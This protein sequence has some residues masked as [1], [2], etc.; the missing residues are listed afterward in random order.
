MNIYDYIVVCFVA[1]CGLIMG[2]MF[3][4]PHLTDSR[5][6][7]ISDRVL[8]RLI[9]LFSLMSFVTAAYSF[10]KREW[11]TGGIFAF[12]VIIGLIVVLMVDTSEEL[13]KKNDPCPMT[14]SQWFLLH[15]GFCINRDGIWWNAKSGT[16]RLWPWPWKCERCHWHMGREWYVYDHAGHRVWLC[17][18]C[19]A[20]TRYE[21]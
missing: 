19:I 21:Q 18:E 16:T 5:S 14:I 20:R 11:I 2:G 10:T 9:C 8:V 3:I 1:S 12:I 6:L 7:P 13:W 17:R 15:L 4:W